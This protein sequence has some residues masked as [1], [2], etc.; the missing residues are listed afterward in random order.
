MNKPLKS[1]FALLLSAA[2]LAAC[3]TVEVYQHQNK[4]SLDDVFIKQGADFSGYTAV[5]IDDVSV[6]YPDEYTPS[7]ENADKAKANL[8]RAQILFKE[9][10]AR[11]L[12]ERYPVTD[13]AGRNV[14]RVHVEFV[15][16]RALR[17][18]A[19]VPSELS[20]YDFN[21]RPGHITMIAQ[22]FDS[23]SG[24]RLARAADLGKQESVGGDGLVDWDA[25]A[26][27]FEYWAEIFSAWMDQMH[28]Q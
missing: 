8:A 18:G 24:E 23:R 5:I 11:S 26:A 13:Q 14:L 19:A 6:W 25:I 22:L 2:L 21:T 9:T 20:R 10:I 3:S 16:L 17:E 28:G 7:A 27:D 4:S 12:S 15:D 1:G